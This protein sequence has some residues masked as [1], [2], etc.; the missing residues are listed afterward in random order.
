MRFVPTGCV[1]AGMKLGKSLFNACGEM[2][3]SEG[4][5]MSLPYIERL[6]QLGINGVYIDDSL[7][8]DIEIQNVISDEVR[9]KAI[10]GIRNNFV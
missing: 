10:Q 4:K 1:R 8:E 2:L 9:N 3:L 7:S 6:Q 5:E